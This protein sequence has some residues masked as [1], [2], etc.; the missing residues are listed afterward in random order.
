MSCVTVCRAAQDV[1]I[2]Q[3]KAVEDEKDEYRFWAKVFLRTVRIHLARCGQM[4]AGRVF[5]CR[6][7]YGPFPE[8][9]PPSLVSSLSG[10]F[11]FW[12]QITNVHIEV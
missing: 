11:D 6:W 4:S 9:L 7:N 2:V 8:L 3:S 10:E 1:E 12:T 5:L